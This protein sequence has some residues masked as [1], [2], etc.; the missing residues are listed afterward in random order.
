[1]FGYSLCTGPILVSRRV[2]HAGNW[3][4]GVGFWSTPMSTDHRD[5]YKQP[6]CESKFIEQ[7][8]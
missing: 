4:V 6:A 2:W 8:L 3:F 5:T 7:T 1:M